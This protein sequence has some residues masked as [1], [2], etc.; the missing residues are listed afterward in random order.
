MIRCILGQNSLQVLAM[1]TAFKEWTVVVDALERGEQILILRKG[2]IREGKAGFQVVSDSFWLF[3]TMFHQQRE[4]VSE[5]AQ[6]RYDEI[7]RNS[8]D[9]EMVAIRSFAKV[10]EHVE[11]E[12]WAQIARLDSSHI[13]REEVIKDRFIWG[14]KQAI[15]ALVVRVYQLP[16]PLEI[17]MLPK[18][19]GCRSWVELEPE[20]PTDG[21]TPV[22]DDKVFSRQLEAFH[23]AIQR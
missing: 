7:R 5:A 19:G 9:E 15:F 10:V 2:G 6:T 21:L 12:D 23:T 11:L 1:Q 22:V 13:W 4:A 17:P 18:Y 14:E 8:P 20:M 16:A 3:P